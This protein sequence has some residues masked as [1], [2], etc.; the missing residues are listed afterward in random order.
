M[1]SIA[2]KPAE[3]GWGSTKKYE[4]NFDKIFGPQTKKKETESQP[5][6]KKKESRPTK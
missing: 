3:T 5:F 4:G 1:H 2:F 6:S